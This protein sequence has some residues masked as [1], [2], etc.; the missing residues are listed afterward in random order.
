MLD[1][2]NGLQGPTKD[3]L[4]HTFLFKTAAKIPVDTVGVHR[5]PLDRNAEARAEMQPGGGDT[6]SLGWIIAR[7]AIIGGRK[8]VSIESPFVLKSTA[9]VDVL[10]EVKHRHTASTL[11]RCVLPKCKGDIATESQKNLVSVPANIVPL[12]HDGVHSFLARTINIDHQ[13]LT[14]WTIKGVG[15]P[16]EG[17]EIS[18][19]PPF[20]SSSV[21]KGVIGEDQVTLFDTSVGS[22]ESESTFAFLTACTIRIGSFS[23]VKSNTEVPEQRMLYFRSPF[24]F[25]NLLALPIAVEVRLKESITSPADPRLVNRQQPPAGTVP[26]LSTSWNGLGVLDCGE[27]VN[28]T[29]A[30]ASDKVQMRVR[31]V[32]TDGDNSRR[33]PGWSSPIFLPSKD[34]SSFENSRKPNMG[35]VETSQM[36]IVDADGVALSLSVALDRGDSFAD[37]EASH[38]NFREF[39]SSFAAGT[40]VVNVFVPYWIVDST[41]EDLEF[42]SGTAV[43]GQLDTR[44]KTKQSGKGTHRPL[45]FGLAEL[46]DN[47]SFLHLPAKSSFD[48]MML[49]ENH[50]SRLTVRKRLDRTSRSN[51]RIQGSPWSDPIPLRVPDDSH[52]DITV[53]AHQDSSYAKT[54]DSDD[55]NRY[56]RFV[57]RSSIVNAPTKFG[58]CMGT[59][60]IHIVN[61]YSIINQTGRDIEIASDYGRAGHILV[62]SAKWPQPFHF[63]DSRPIRFR[64]KEFGWS[65]SGK[66][67]IRLNRREVSMRLRHKMKA[68][69][70]IV[71]VEVL[72]RKKAASTV[73]IFRQSVYPPFRLENHT[74]HPLTFGQSATSISVDETD[75]DVMLLPYQTADFAWDEPELRKRTL[76]IAASDSAVLHD[77]FVVGRFQLDQIAPG[78]MLHLESDLLAGEI[79]ADGPIRVLRITDSSMPRL[80]SFRHDELSDFQHRDEG[81]KGMTLSL[82]IRLS[83]GIGVSVV[84]WLPQELLYARFD[85]IR[86]DQKVDEKTD[87][88]SISV[89]NIKLNNQLWVTPYPV[90]LKMGKRT[91]A[92]RSRRRSRRHDAVR[93]SWKRS[94]NDHG[95]YGNL[96]L[97]ENV[98]VSSE[99][100]FV[101]ID[102]VLAGLLERMFRQMKGVGFNAKQNLPF[103]TRDDELKK[104]LEIVDEP[105]ADDST[106]RKMLAA[107][108]SGADGE[109]MTTAAVAAKLRANPLPI[110]TAKTNAGT[111]GQYRR[112]TKRPRIDALSKPQHKYYIERLRV[113]AAKADLSWS[114]PLPGFVSSLL[115][116][117]LTFERLPLGLRPY[118]SSHAY[119][120]AKDHLQAMKSHYLSF[121]RILDLMMSL[122][123]N[124]TFLFR[125]V[126]YTMRETCAS[127][128]DGW[129]NDSKQIA[130]NLSKAVTKNSETLAM[131][132]DGLPTLETNRS[133]ALTRILLTPFIRSSTFVLTTFGGTMGWFAAALRYGPQNGKHHLSRGLVR[134]RNPRLFA[135]M[136]GHDLL[137]EYVEGENA[138]KALLSRVRMGIHL[139]EGYMFHTEGVRQPKTKAH[140]YRQRKWYTTQLQLYDFDPLPLIFMVTSERVMIL[141]GQLDRHF[142]SIVWEAMFMDLVHIELIPAEKGSVTSTS[143]D[144]LILWYLAPM[145][146][147]KTDEVSD[148]G[149][150]EMHYARAIAAGIDVLNYKSIFVPADAG[151][152]ILAKMGN[153]DNRLSCGVP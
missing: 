116:R 54:E 61:R 38:G 143:M 129:A 41:N 55:L 87:H 117:A 130:R 153:V 70:T 69:S 149:N 51:F 145:R 126:V 62:R 134:S 151:G 63:D 83:H 121:W 68:Q 10:C 138:G 152:Q 30:K 16:E 72:E 67:T 24:V 99:P 5:Y 65:W 57:L 123:Y 125:A 77:G 115:L 11:W 106:S 80:S 86:I 29:G 88:V 108:E 53:L 27:S 150:R 96:T 7:V 148:N 137:V 128:F 98:E 102:G 34:V 2:T 36:K 73:L 43:A 19:P 50:S 81:K 35:D 40:R 118:S 141:N 94:V 17:V 92:S 3:L 52:Y 14:D 95:G 6:R 49:G 90:L 79:V 112:A 140:S 147:Q 64:F 133:L 93:I 71:T 39:S 78:T 97:L 25:K 82:S 139:G 124:P 13:T 89:G 4:S 58:G 100:V 47:D 66:F 32:G 104:V 9:D 31:F 1:S 12:L 59:K 74:M 110:V 107:V 105:S 45:T 113:S 114:G 48:V 135:Q 111:I 91:D 103:G 84:D 15:F 46:L 20:S 76:F 109:M 26:V 136:D 21:T 127:V 56:N 146:L 131:Y 42:F 132:E 75:A 85:N 37:L 44:Y 120:D 60:L 119:G 33:F 23:G 122:S 8:L 142:C 101:S 28:W 144:E 22:W 18:T